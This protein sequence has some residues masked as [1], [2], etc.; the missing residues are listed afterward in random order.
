MPGPDYCLGR[1]DT[2]PFAT[3]SFPSGV[4]E[5]IA[6]LFSGAVQVPL[7]KRDYDRPAQERSRPASKLLLECCRVKH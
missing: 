3:L 7:K 1:T 6:R 2:S 4:E 5:Q